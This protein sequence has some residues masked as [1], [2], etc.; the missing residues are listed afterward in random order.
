MAMTGGTPKLVKTGYGDYGDTNFPI[1]LYVYYK[2][3]QSV[4]DNKSTITCGMYVTTPNNW[5]IG[6]WVKSSDS[7]VGTK[8]ITFNGEIPNFDGTYWIA[9]NKSFTVNHNDDGTGKATIY[10]KWGVNSPWGQMQN[11]S[12]SFEITLPTIARASTVSCP[13]SGTMKGDVT[14]SIGRKST[15]AFKH[16]LKYTF[17]GTTGTIATGV[18]A[19]SYTW[20]VP[21]LA[22]KCN[23]AKSGKCII[24]CETYSGNTKIGTSTAEMTLNVPAATEPSV[25]DIKTGSRLS[26]I[27]MGSTVR[28]HVSYRASTNFTHK[29]S[30]S[31]GSVS[32]DF[33]SGFT[34]H[35]DWPVS[36]DLAK[37]IRNATSG[38]CTI[39]CVTYNGT[40]EVGTKTLRFQSRCR[41]TPPRSL[42]SQNSILTKP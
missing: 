4:A 29:L 32:D 16:T 15:T 26:S 42:L 35:Y 21:D 5:D 12:G 10:W 17:G 22:A 37:Q 9:E 39:T 38:T 2:T 3:S 40:A 13:A 7:Y 27:A 25:W 8:S 19:A 41:T 1:K 24:T 28:I 31:F 23:N 18:N 36:L 6:P 30:Y 34:S 20:S 14:I 33:G 11:P